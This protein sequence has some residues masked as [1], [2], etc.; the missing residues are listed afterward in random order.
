MRSISISRMRYSNDVSSIW[1]SMTLTVCARI[2]ADVAALEHRL[3][4]A[5]WRGVAAPADGPEVLEM[6]RFDGVV[7]GAGLQALDRRL[8]SG[9][10]PSGSGSE[11]PAARTRLMISMPESFAIP[12]ST[13]ARSMDIRIAAYSPS[14]PSAASSTLK[15]APSAARPATRAM[16]SRLRQSAGASYD[17]RRTEPV[18]ASTVTIHTWVVELQQPQPVNGAPALLELYSA[19]AT[20]LPCIA[21]ELSPAA[22]F[23]E[24]S[25][26]PLAIH[27]PCSSLS[28][29]APAVNVIL[30]RDLH[31]CLPRS[32][33]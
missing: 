6:K 15:P 25:P 28:S 13:I 19:R 31:R 12:R 22:S 20:T 14:S 24:I 17:Y 30:S 11:R 1:L 29:I 32:S 2:E 7:V 26:F 27:V 3:R 8:P 16:H 9:R 33:R 23:K 10:G 4:P 5:A 18:E 21:A